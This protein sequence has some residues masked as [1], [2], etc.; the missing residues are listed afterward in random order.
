MGGGKLTSYKLIFICNEISIDFLNISDFT[1]KNSGQEDAAINI[2]SSYENTIKDNQ[3]INNSI[4]ILIFDNSH[5]NHI[6]S[7]LIKDNYQ[8]IFNKIQGKY[9][10]HFSNEGDNIGYS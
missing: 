6:N 8:G 2:A 4:G 3:L 9:Y 10:N 5:S 1:I 7:D